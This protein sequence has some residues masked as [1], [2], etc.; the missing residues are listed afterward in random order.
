MTS[1]EWLTCLDLDAMLTCARRGRQ[2]SARKRRL[3]A[4]ACCRKLV[5]LL[6]DAH[7][8]ALALAE[9][10]ADGL[11]SKADLAEAWYL[12]HQDP[13]NL[14]GHAAW[15]ACTAARPGEEALTQEYLSTVSL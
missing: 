3:F 5:R 13:I 6:P 2:F 10:F 7:R 1:Q 4:C 11:A 9:R 8:R 12:A 15:A 14:T